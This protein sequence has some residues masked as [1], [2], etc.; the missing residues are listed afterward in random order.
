MAG[1]SAR[2]VP[3]KMCKSVAAPLCTEC[4]CVCICVCVCGLKPSKT[5]LTEN[6]LKISNQ[7]MRTAEMSVKVETQAYLLFIDLLFLTT[8]YAI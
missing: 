3:L 8:M 4:V 6:D 1:V 2:D 7:D 5:D